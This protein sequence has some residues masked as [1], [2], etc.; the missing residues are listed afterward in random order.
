MS[1]LRVL[2]A[3]DSLTMRKHLVEA[4][5]A[6]PDCAIAGEAEDGARAVEL[7][8]E[9]RP[10][11][12]TMD[13]MM[14]RMTGLEATEQIMAYT[15]TPILVV[16]SSFNRGDLLRTYD[17]LAAGALDVLEKPTGL[18]P[19]GSWE[20]RFR[21]AVKMISRIKVIT[22]PRARLRAGAQSRAERAALTAAELAALLPVPA[23]S[24]PAGLPATEAPGNYR[25]VALGTSTGGPAALVELLGQLPE[26]FPLPILL[27]LHLA[28][29]FEHA[30]AEWLGG[31]SN[32]RVERAVDRM[33]LPERGQARVIL[34]P[35]QRHLE[36]R[37][38]LL[39]L[40]DGPERNACRPSVDCLFESVAC[41]LGPAA[42]GC[43]LTGMGRDGAAGL[44]AMKQAGA[45][46]VAQDEASSAVWGMPREAVLLD[47]A[48]LVLPLSEMARTLT[49]FCP[50]RRH[51]E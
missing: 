35:A 31:H 30:F 7:C 43:L 50:A 38:G 20:R 28:P 42:I 41:D 46:T 32:L 36:L 12:V 13:M 29:S 37:N 1:K 5:R 15:P 18:E 34:A 45:M 8:R 9:L 6:D 10:D 33:P 19:D 24:W 21:A 16:S 48:R 47:A 27:V 49:L 40:L 26:D 17:A 22:H 39:R 25:A 44:L 51:P 23:R 3:D 14:P 4:L 11:V 2:I